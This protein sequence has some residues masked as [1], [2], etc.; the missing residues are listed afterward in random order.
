MTTTTTIRIRDLTSGDEHDLPADT[1]CRQA[2]YGEVSLGTLEIGER[3]DVID[4][5][6]SDYEGRPVWWPSER[7]A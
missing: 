1:R 3:A 5:G 7:I 6:M 4:D 2:Q